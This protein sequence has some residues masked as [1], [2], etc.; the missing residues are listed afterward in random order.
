[1]SEIKVLITGDFCPVHR[2]ENID[3]SFVDSIL[4][5]FLPTIRSA[6]LA[7]TNLECP[8]TSSKKRIEKT[9]PNLKG[10]EQAV[11]FL[12][13][14]GFSLC[15]LANNHIFDYGEQG[16]RDTFK[17][18]K[19]KEISYVGAGENKEE[20]A[21]PYIF[22]KEGVKIGILN[23]AENEWSTT[24][25]GQPGANPIDPVH[26][27]RSISSLKPKVDYIILITHGGHE[28]Y[29]LP[30]PRMVSWFRGFIDMGADAVINHHTHC[31]SGHEEYNGKP[32]FYSIGNFLFDN[33]NERNSIWNQGMAV[34]L[35]L[36]KK[37]MN[38]SSLYFEQCNDEV[39]LNLLDLNDHRS[40]YQSIQKINNTIA[41]P[42]QLQTAFEEYVTKKKNLYNAYLE[43]Y[44]NKYLIAL[45]NRG[46]FPSLWRRR[47][48]LLLENIMRCEAHRDVLLQLLQSE[49]SHTP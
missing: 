4:G 33:P 28:M 3:A 34:Q 8:I 22:E 15:T 10:D 42:D 23:V 41:Q 9:G 7:I 17:V 19:N 32:I 18:L 29:P 36:S 35:T 39:K 1:M 31:I 48:K 16:L 44:S 46:L 25:N 13:H 38:F 30:S 45:R 47:K 6:D 27:Y 24:H 11:D 2:L 43:P 14:A 21:I 5:D 20:A 37:T 26:V 12:S 40:L 49:N